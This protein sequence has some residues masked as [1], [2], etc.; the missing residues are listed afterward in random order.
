M[1]LTFSDRGTVSSARTFRVVVSAVMS[2]LL[3]TIGVAG[4]TTLTEG[5]RLRSSVIDVEAATR[6]PGTTLTLRS[7]RALDPLD[8]ETVRVE[9]EALFSIEQTDLDVVI[10]FTHPVQSNTTYTVSLDEVSPRGAG[11]TTSWSTSFSTPAEDIVFIRSVGTDTELVRVD[12]DGSEPQ[13]LYR[14]PGI[15]GF[16]PVGVVYAVHRVVGE[17]SILE[18]VDPVTGGVDRIALSP[19]DTVVSL[20]SAPWGTSVVVT[21]DT[22]VSGS[23]ERSVVA[24]LDTVGSR[25]PEVVL[26]VDGGPLRAL[27][28]AVSPITGHIVALLRDRSL[29]LYEPLTKVTIPLGS[30]VELW[31]F[32]ATGERVVFVDSLGTL[33]LSIR[34]REELRIPAG[35]LEGFPVLHEVTT[36]SSEGLSYQRV[37]LPSL[38]G[39]PSFVL[40]T[41]ADEEGVHTRLAGST[42]VPGSIG[43]LQ[44][45]PN[46]QYLAIETNP[47][48]SALGYAGLTTEER[49]RS[50]SL[51]ILDLARDSV[52]FDAPGYAF[53]W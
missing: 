39:G 29:V 16:S 49:T 32:D 28:V 24:L 2:V 12:I 38:D 30:A 1:S 41:E 26:G 43:A 31:G 4:F 42:S 8:P 45:S 20:A 33:A 13:V 6:T 18:L 47:I 51:V 11:A 48:T 19:E 10:T 34:E 22:E 27:K 5:P 36:V 15:A 52:V 40:V 14:A 17:E 44:L 7:D 3:V 25:L 35:R 21:M 46:G 37:V 50:T 9:P 53:A 23:Q